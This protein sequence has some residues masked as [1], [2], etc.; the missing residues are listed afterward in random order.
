MM[1]VF[2]VACQQATLIPSVP[3]GEDGRSTEKVESDS[4]N[5]DVDVEAE[6]WQGSIDA[7][8]EFGGEEQEGGEE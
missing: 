8:F 6:G 4:T 2:S 3:K 1:L 5:V 7:D